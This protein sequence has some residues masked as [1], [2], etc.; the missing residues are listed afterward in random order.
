MALDPNGP[1]RASAV[2][3]VYSGGTDLAAPDWAL[4]AG[5][6][7][8]RLV[9]SSGREP[10]LAL[11]VLENAPA[12]TVVNTGIGPD[13]SDDC[14]LVEP[15]GFGLHTLVKVTVESGGAEVT[16]FLGL[17]AAHRYDL[18]AERFIVEARDY[19]WLLEKIPVLGREVY[20]PSSETYQ[21]IPEALPVFN[22]AGAADRYAESMSL[23]AFAAAA[24]G[25]AAHWQRGDAWNYLRYHWNVSPPEGWISTEDWL[26]WP[27][28]DP[29]GALGF[30]YEDSGAAPELALGG[31]T[32]AAA[33]DRLVRGAGAYSWTLEYVGDQARL[34][35]FG[36]LQPGTGQRSLSLARGTPG[37]T[38]LTERP[39]VTGGELRLDAARTVARVRAL[40]A[41]EAYDVSFDTLA[42]TLVPSWSSAHQAAWLAL[43]EGERA[44]AY[45]AV[46]S[47][48]VVPDDLD[49]T[50]IFANSGEETACC[51][52]RARALGALL[53]SADAGTVGADG[54]PVRLGLQLWRSQDGGLSWEPPPAGVTATVLAG[55]P[56]IELS[57]GARQELVRS[58]GGAAECWSWDGQD[59]AHALRVTAS[60]VADRRLARSEQRAGTPWPA[61]EAVLVA[62]QCRYQARRQAWVPAVEGL[63]A[64]EGGTPELFGQDAP[65]PIRDDGPALADLA[66]EALADLARPRL[67]GEILLPG[68]RADVAVGDWLVKL[69]GG[70][71][72]PDLEVRSAVRRVE[73]RAA[74]QLTAVSV[75]D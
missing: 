50:E 39:E 72:R 8:A 68:L 18:G 36:T 11:I 22:A 46:F 70:G 71:L 54:R 21:F 75:G 59:S 41:P 42:G 45:P 48:W 53:L 62:P 7:L 33:V 27:E 55:S 1:V 64:A 60:L 3:R 37:G 31:L 38:V 9:R 49:W 30:L 65:D 23:P 2:V 57:A 10:S 20:R 63:P 25:S 5:A 56:G 24:S 40:G 16:A 13:G 44:R 52:E 43:P 12:D 74:E 14:P 26:D 19:R 17:V 69:S 61:G 73:W 15:A 4:A 66:A 47:R 35:A 58:P 67:T 28:A 29:E 32:L 34:V 6:R 51:E